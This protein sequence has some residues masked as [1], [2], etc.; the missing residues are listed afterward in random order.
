MSKRLLKAWLKDNPL[1]ADPTDKTAVISSNGTL[2]EDDLLDE[3]M[4][5]GIELKRDTLKSVVTRYKNKITDRV[6]SGYN[7]NIGLVYM[8]PLIKGVF[9]DKNFNPAVNSVYVH[10]SQGASLRKASADTNVEILGERSDL[11][12]L[13]AITDMT[14]GNT[15]GTLTKGRNAELKGAF[16]KIAGDDPANGITFRN[17]ATGAETK[18][19][20]G[21]IVLNEP[22]RL[23]IMVP[24]GL[25]AGE[26]ELKIA[27]QFTSNIKKLLNNPRS[28][29]LGVP[30]IVG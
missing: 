12:E 9:Y 15:D 1:T 5:E 18:L 30:V 4:A 23:L 7:V 8:R 2:T 25:E 21:D 26:Y 17:T 16:I 6:L 20:A 22:S 28:V 29:T 19:S 14:T 13:Y 24:A 10:V 11:I 3:I 27:T